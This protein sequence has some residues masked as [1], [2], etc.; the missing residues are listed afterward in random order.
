MFSSFIT[1]FMNFY[2]LDDVVGGAV[3]SLARRL[4]TDRIRG[5]NSRSSNIPTKLTTQHS[6][7][8]N[9]TAAELGLMTRRYPENLLGA[10]S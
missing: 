4:R 1:Y 3:S 10:Q 6:H 2:G 8:R 7:E 9:H 5:F